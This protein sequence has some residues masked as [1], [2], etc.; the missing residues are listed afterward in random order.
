MIMQH[1]RLIKKTEV[2]L[3]V[4]RIMFVEQAQVSQA[5]TGLDAM[6][7]PLLMT[8]CFNQRED[9]GFGGLCGSG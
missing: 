8:A 6:P 4:D 2:A 7:S 9:T 5:F 3:R 1:F